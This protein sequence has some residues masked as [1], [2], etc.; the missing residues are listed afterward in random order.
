MAIE[1]NSLAAWTQTRAALVATLQATMALLENEPYSADPASTYQQA[2]AQSQ[3]IF[4]QLRA[5]A[6]V[7]LKQLDA[8]IAAGPQVAAIETAARQA[9]QEADALQNA[10][11]TIASITSA[12]NAATSVATKLSGLPFLRA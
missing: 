3:D 9:K 5:L 1:M 8:Q 10:A 11:A 4:A 12:V 7:G 2:E 6:V